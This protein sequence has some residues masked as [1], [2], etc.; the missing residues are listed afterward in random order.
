[1][2]LLPL[3]YLN[4]SI[5]KQIITGM[6]NSLKQLIASQCPVP[7]WLRKVGLAGLLLFLIKGLAWIAVTAVVYLGFF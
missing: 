4:T 7:V 1:M 2:A 3:Y 5:Y 6:E